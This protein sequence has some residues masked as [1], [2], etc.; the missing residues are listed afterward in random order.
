MFGSWGDWGWGWAA[1]FFGMML[2]MMAL[3]FWFNRSSS[4]SD[5]SWMF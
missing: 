5:S 1:M 3:F 2:G 4:T